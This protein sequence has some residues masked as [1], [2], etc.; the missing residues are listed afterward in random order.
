MAR[1]CLSETLQDTI[2]DLIMLR[3]EALQ[4]YKVL[5]EELFRDVRL[6]QVLLYSIKTQF[7]AQAPG[8]SGYFLLTLYT[9]VFLYWIEHTE[10]ETMVMLDR[11]LHT[12]LS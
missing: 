3:L 12:M 8:L 2:F 4:P 7:L 11:L 10:E 1:F 6:S 5:V 9:T